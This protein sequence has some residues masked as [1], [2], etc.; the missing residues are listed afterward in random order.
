[1]SPTNETENEMEVNDTE[2]Q[3]V[4]PGFQTLQD[5]TKVIKWQYYFTLKD[6]IFLNT[7][8]IVFHHVWWSGKLHLWVTATPKV[9][10]KQVYIIISV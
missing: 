6:E 2:Q 1:M 5:F 3:D 10:S 7:K 8:Y 9:S 4:L